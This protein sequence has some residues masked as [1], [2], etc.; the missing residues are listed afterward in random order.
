MQ[1]IFPSRYNLIL[2]TERNISNEKSQPIIRA[3]KMRTSIE[4]PSILHQGVFARVEQVNEEYGVRTSFQE[5]AAALIF[6]A[7]SLTPDQHEIMLRRY[8][9]ARVIDVL[10][11]G[12]TPHNRRKLGRPKK[13]LE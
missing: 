2:M 11:L 4:M 1:R 12:L 8:R 10:R 7:L 3:P 13:N 6:D 5:I 9:R